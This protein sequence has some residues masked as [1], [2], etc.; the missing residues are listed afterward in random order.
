MVDS[1]VRP[2]NVTHTALLE[3]MSALPR[4]RF[5]PREQADIAYVDAD[6][7]LTEKRFILA[8]RSFAKMLN[9]A[10][11]KETDVV[12][13]IG[14][15]LGYSTA[16]LAWLCASVVGVEENPSLA[17]EAQTNLNHS[18]IDNG[19]VHT[20]SLALGVA[21]HAPYDLIVIEGAVQ[22]IPETIYQQ[23]AENGRIVCLFAE[24][25][26]GVCRIGHKINGTVNWRFAFN[27]NAPLLPGFER[28]RTFVF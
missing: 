20:G 5:V 22:R 1:Q 2:A 12:L 16:I 14:C 8:P 21:E 23:I 7:M 11:P 27:A 19:L 24:A 26:L 28:E 17:Q 18:A 6:L 3:A 25:A 4:E 9:A 15:A 10:Q 13:D